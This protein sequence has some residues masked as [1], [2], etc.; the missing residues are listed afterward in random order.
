MDM[1]ETMETMEDTAEVIGIEETH[2]G[3]VV[4]AE[5]DEVPNE[6]YTEIVPAE[7]IDGSVQ[8]DPNLPPENK[9]LVD[10][11]NADRTFVA[12]RQIM[13]A[14]NQINQ[15]ASVKDM[16]LN[17]VNSMCP[18]AR[19]SIVEARASVIDLDAMKALDMRKEEDWAKILECYTMEDGSIVAFS[20]D[21]DLNDL[22]TREMHRDFLVY[23]RSIKEENEK[24]EIV[25]KKLNA[26]IDEL[27]NNFE[28][29]FGEEEAQKL[30]NYKD[31]TE[32]YRVWIG[33]TLEREDI[34]DAARAMLT[35][36]KKADDDGVN[37]EYII[38][39][40]Q[41]QISKKKDSGSILS[42]FNRSFLDVAQRAKKILGS[43]FAKYKFDAA[44]ETFYDF[45]KRAFPGEYDD[46]NNLFIYLLCRYIKYHH[47]TLDNNSMITIG[48]TL[49][50]M[51]FMLKEEK[52]RPESAKDFADA[53]RDLLDLVITNKPTI[54]MP[55]G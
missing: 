37:L 10:L 28:D 33:K 47:E 23:L 24:F 55:Q 45:E 14:R 50:H 3:P 39:D 22:T 42:G 9:E 41:A 38:K 35:K 40:I 21:P 20:G 2:D 29:I 25:E 53:V 13:M 44:L 4:D 51:G 1:N 32:Y 7:E 19:L 43:K 30:R 26:E 11:M 16:A 27:I 31:F 17:K 15:I 18:D 8:A 5:F 46:Y 36:I 48:E 54:K 52:D 6:P 49:T 12:T 34:S